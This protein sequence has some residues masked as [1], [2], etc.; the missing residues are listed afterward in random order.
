MINNDVQDEYVRSQPQPPLQR[1]RI[2]VEELII[3]NFAT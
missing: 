3:E 1:A 2:T